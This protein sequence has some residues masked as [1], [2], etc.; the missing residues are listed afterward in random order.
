MQRH[1]TLFEHLWLHGLYTGIAQD[2]LPQRIAEVAHAYGISERL[3]Q[4]P[5]QLSGG[6]RQRF[7]LARAL[8]HDPEIVILDEPTVALD[9]HVRRQVWHCI[10]S[11][12]A[13]GRLVILTT[14]Y[15]EEAE[16]LADRICFLQKG[17]V[18]SYDTLAN[19]KVQFGKAT[20][21]EMMMVLIEE[22]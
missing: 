9:V 3:Q 12:R 6:Y 7:G 16:Q 21:D 5:S 13:E 11:L 20:L 2:V 17:V 4:Y 10:Q 19:L 14:H 22:Q 18:H 1:F 8:L 15:L